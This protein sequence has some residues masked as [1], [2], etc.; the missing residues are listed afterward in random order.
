MSIRQFK[1]WLAPAIFK[2]GIYS[3]MIGFAFWYA[4]PN[5]FILFT[6]NDWTTAERVPGFF[7]G[8]CVGMALSTLLSALYWVWQVGG[9]LVLVAVR[10]T[11]RSR[12]RR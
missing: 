8:F 1:S 12:R 6:P 11:G 7:V 4:M 9:W 2:S 5:G 3:L 10:K